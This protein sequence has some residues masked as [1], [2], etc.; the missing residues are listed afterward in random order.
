MDF[1]LQW[2]L[3]R[4]EDRNSHDPSLAIYIFCFVLFCCVVLRN[5]P[6]AGFTYRASV[7]T[8]ELITS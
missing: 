5:L 7:Q 4:S 3:F 8:S 6:E 2:W 1:N